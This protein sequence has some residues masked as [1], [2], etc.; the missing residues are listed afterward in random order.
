MDQMNIGKKIKIRRE[1]LGY[2]LQD[3]ANKLEV[4][5]STIM[6]WENG[7]TNRI[8]LPTIEKLAQILQTSPGILM[9]YEEPFERNTTS[10]SAAPD[11][12]CLIPVVKSLFSDERLFETRN[13]INYEL[14]DGQY[15]YDSC[16]YWFVS[17]DS[18]A[19]ALE[20][21]DR[22]LV[23]QQNHIRDGQLG[24]FLLNETEYMIRKY[25]SGKDIR[26]CACNPYYPAIRIPK[27]ELHRLKI[28]G[29]VLESKRQW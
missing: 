8:K 1:Q 15:R 11:D 13:I 2:S 29:V 28:I 27:E 6:R 24:V 25:S 9:G 7:E 16:F 20:D 18:M 4:H 5:R 14:A 17:N 22:I 3:I 26:L 10:H 23:K 21:S 19:P 12:A